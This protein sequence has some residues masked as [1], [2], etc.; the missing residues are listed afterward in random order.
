MHSVLQGKNGDSIAETIHLMRFKEIITFILR[1]I[2]KLQLDSLR[3][4]YFLGVLEV[5][6]TKATISF[7]TSVHLSVRLSASSSK[8]PT[9]R[10]CVIFYVWIFTTMCR[11]IPVLFKISRSQQTLYMNSPLFTYFL[12]VTAPYT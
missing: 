4:S 2:W 9:G 1:V 5:K 3:R 11:H 8:R 6:L 7:I 10:N 12:H